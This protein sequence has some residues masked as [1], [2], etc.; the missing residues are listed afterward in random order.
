[1]MQTRCQQKNGAE[2]PQCF[3]KNEWVFNGRVGYARLNR[4]P[5][6]QERESKK[7]LS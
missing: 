1:M 3:L 7:N 4:R 2:A 5:Q 6:E